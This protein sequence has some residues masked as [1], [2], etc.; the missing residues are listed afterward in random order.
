VLAALHAGCDNS[1]SCTL[2][3]DS[4][5]ARMFQAAKFALCGLKRSAPLFLFKIENA[6]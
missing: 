4:G 1:P 2:T 5:F 3:H 6:Q